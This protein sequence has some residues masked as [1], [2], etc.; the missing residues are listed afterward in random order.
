[1]NSKY[2]VWMANAGLVV[3]AVAMV[4]PFFA[5]PAS[6]VF[7]II[8]SIGAA[9]CLAGRLLTPAQ[10]PTLRVR[11]LVRLLTWSA[12]F[13]CVAAFFMWYNEIPR[14]W[15]AFVLAGG[16]IQCYVSLM[17]PREIRKANK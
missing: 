11:R 9:L 7:R 8:F 16:I 5:G 1:M 6:V 12:L 4:I 17:L 13:F 10:G 14:D 15:L 3:I 2:T